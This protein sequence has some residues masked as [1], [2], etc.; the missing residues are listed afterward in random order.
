MAEGNDDAALVPLRHGTASPYYRYEPRAISYREA[1]ALTSSRQFAGFVF[2]RLV[3]KSAETTFATPLPESLGISRWEELSDDARATL[4]PERR[5]LEQRGFR[6]ELIFTVPYFPRPDEAFT[7]AFLDPSA[8]TLVELDYTCKVLVRREGEA[9][10]THRELNR[11]ALSQT[12]NGQ[13]LL[14]TSVKAMMFSLPEI[15]LEKLPDASLVEVVER[16]AERL[17][18]SLAKESPHRRSSELIAFSR[19]SVVEFI[20]GLFRRNIES[21]SRRGVLVELDEAELERL[22]SRSALAAN[23]PP[24]ASKAKIAGTWLMLVL[25]FA[26]AYIFG[27]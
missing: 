13:I 6:L 7:L 14:T 26:L 18:E 10:K 2:F 19:S 15:A 25:M 12:A 27:G 5:M 16:H 24:G 22:E 17:A 8:T 3:S 23:A 9:S 4:E 1:R 21:L 11:R 20:L